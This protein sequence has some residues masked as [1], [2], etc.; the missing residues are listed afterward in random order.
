MLDAHYS[1]HDTY[2]NHLTDV[3]ALCQIQSY[4]SSWQMTVYLA[5][6]RSPDKFQLCSFSV[7]G[8][9]TFTVLKLWYRFLPV[10]S[11]LSN[12]YN[13]LLVSISGDF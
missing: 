6:V 7:V 10:H 5:L 12:L 9:A 11:K 3:N 13:V 8:A 1:N 4:D 2:Q